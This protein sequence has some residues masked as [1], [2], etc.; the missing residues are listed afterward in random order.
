MLEVKRGEVTVR[1][2]L[3]ETARV[4]RAVVVSEREEEGRSANR[5]G[6]GAVKGRSAAM[7]QGLSGLFIL[8]DW[9]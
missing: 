5:I 2:D 7:L 8:D 1:F 9:T 4:G 3:R 6:S